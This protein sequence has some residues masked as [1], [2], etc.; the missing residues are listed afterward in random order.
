MLSSHL[1]FSIVP[2]LILVGM[3]VG[4]QAP[5]IGIL[6]FRFIESASL[7]DFLGRLSILFLLFHL[8]LEFSVGRLPNAGRSII[9]GGI[10]YMAINLPLG[11]LLPYLLGRF[12]FSWRGSPAGYSGSGPDC[13]R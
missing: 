1:H 3:L 7:I 8:G 6:D 5:H 10:I 12:I 9:R 13:H 4:P 2:L 11:L